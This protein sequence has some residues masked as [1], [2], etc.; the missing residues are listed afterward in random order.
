MYLTYARHRRRRRRARRSHPPEHCS[1]TAPTRTSATC[2][3]GCPR[4]SPRSPA[5]S[6]R[7]SSDRFASRAIEHSIAL[8]RALLAAGAD[9]ND[10]QALYNR[11]FGDDDD[12]LVLLFEFGLG[13]GNGRALARAARRRDR[14]SRGARAWSA[15]VGGDARPAGSGAAAARP[16]RRRGGPVCGR[17][18]GHRA[19]R[20]HRQHRGGLD[21]RRA[22]DAGAQIRRPRRLCC[23]GARWR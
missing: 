9:P 22:W 7:A 16:R 11:M 10:P 18:N 1:T 6:E 21:P 13:R 3:T 4:R 5:R 14:P 20:T 2:G 23:C 19:R 8:A 15:A 17:P 12:H